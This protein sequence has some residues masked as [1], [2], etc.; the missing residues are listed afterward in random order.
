MVMVM[1]VIVFSVGSRRKGRPVKT[2]GRARAL[3]LIEQ[4]DCLGS[5]ARPSHL[6]ERVV[7]HEAGLCPRERH[8]KVLRLGKCQAKVLAQMLDE[9]AW[10]EVSCSCARGKTREGNRASHAA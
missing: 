7:Q 1:V 3:V 9:E 8:L 6:A 5:H 2:C 4:L 10:L